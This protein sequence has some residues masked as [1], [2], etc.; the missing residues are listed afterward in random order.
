MDDYNPSD[1]SIGCA[2]IMLGVILALAIW[3]AILGGIRG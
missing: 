1:E 2:A 3:G